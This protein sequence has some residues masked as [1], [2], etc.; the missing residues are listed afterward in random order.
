M[1]NCL[2][3]M[4]KDDKLKIVRRALDLFID[5]RQCCKCD[6]YNFNC[7]HPYCVH[8]HSC[9]TCLDIKIAE[10]ELE[11]LLED[12]EHGENS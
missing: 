8:D 7:K 3:K 10:D 12:I 6:G 5:I 1:K 2:G 11:E 9:E 4:N